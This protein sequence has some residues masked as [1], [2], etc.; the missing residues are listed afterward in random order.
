MAR[1]PSVPSSATATVAASTGVGI[2]PGAAGAVLGG[3]APPGVV[4]GTV[5][6]VVPPGVVAGAAV[7]GA[8]VISENP[9]LVAGALE[10]ELPKCARDATRKPIPMTA[11]PAI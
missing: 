5:G 8:A 6:A 3:F 9:V 4:P 7:I 2:E 11:A 1:V 10:S